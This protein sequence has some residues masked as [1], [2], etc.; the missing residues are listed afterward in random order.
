M[1]GAFTVSHCYN[2]EQTYQNHR[3][4]TCTKKPVSETVGDAGVTGTETGVYPSARRGQGDKGGRA[5][6]G[7]DSLS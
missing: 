2:A 5:A 6:Q 3:H 4:T 7:T 1:I